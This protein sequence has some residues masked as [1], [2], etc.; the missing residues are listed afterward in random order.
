MHRP[1]RTAAVTGR[2]LVAVCGAPS[3]RH[4]CGRAGACGTGP[5]AQSAGPLSRRTSIRRTSARTVSSCSLCAAAPR[6]P[7]SPR[8]GACWPRSACSTTPTRAAEPTFDD[9]T[10]L[11][12]RHFQQRRGISVDGIVGAG[13]L[14][15]AD[16]ARTGGSA[17]ACWSTSPA[18]LLAGDDVTALQTQL[19]ELGYDLGRAD[20]IFGAAHRPGRCARSSATTAWCADGICGPGH[21]ARAAAARPAR[22]RRAPAAAARAW[23]RS[24]ASGP[25]LLGKRIVIDPGHG[26]DDRGVAVTTAS[27]RPTSPGTSPPA[28]RAGSTALGVHDLAHPRPAQRRDRRGPGRARQRGRRRSG[29]VAARR[30]VRLAARQRRRALLLR[31]AARSSSTIGERLADLVQRELVARTGLLD[32]R[33]HGKTLGAAAADPDARGPG[34]G[35]LPDL[36]ASTARGWSTRSSATPS[37][38][39]CS[40]PS[41]GCTC[42]RRT[43]RRPASCG[44]R[45]S[46]R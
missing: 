16:R 42:R 33:I 25:S 36:A 6:A 8:S 46:P 14:R 10:E 37:P 40:S 41:S 38:R 9:R 19:L 31:R 3:P 26:G 4:G 11:A 12:V 21:A 29:A 32:G 39:A 43:I 1:R 2:P 20:G 45:P 34:R 35:R 30:R 24:S 28:S 22:R 7:P 5:E 13:D 23:P 44:S 17:T 18:Q 15:R 27:T